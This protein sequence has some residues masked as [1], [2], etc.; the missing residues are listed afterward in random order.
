[1]DERLGGIIKAVKDA[2]IEEDTVFVI[3]GDHG[4]INVDYRV[5]LNNLLLENNLI[6]EENGQW[7]GG[8]I[9][10]LGGSAYLHLKEGDKEAESLA[11]RILNEAKETGEYGIENIH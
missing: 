7:N 9:F 2:G 1:M 8:L 3:S 11:I 10:N 6:Y 5:Y 4:Q